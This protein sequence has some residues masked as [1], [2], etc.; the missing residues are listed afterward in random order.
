MLAGPAIRATV[1]DPAV[2]LLPDGGRVRVPSYTA[3]WLGRHG[4]VGGRRPSQ[5]RLPGA[6]S[7]LAALYDE[8]PAAADRALLLAIGVL[9]E[10]DDADPADVLDR[11]ADPDR[12]LTRDQLR[13]WD[14]W[15]AA[16][17]QGPAPARVRAVRDGQ[18]VVVEAADAVVVDAPDLLALLGKLAIVPVAMAAAADLA[19]RLDLLL[20]S[21]LADY[22]VVS[23]GVVE[24]DAVVHDGLRVRD[25]DG[26]VRDV[27]W[28]LV[29]DVLHVDRAAYAVGLGRG[30]AWRDGEWS[31]RHRRTEALGHL[32]GGSI[33][34]NEDDLDD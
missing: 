23:T 14:R 7:L 28:R 8:A 9:D 31:Q 3:W 26:E 12:T 16:S 10:L 2:V 30:R 4:V 25:A 20:A 11:L 32:V 13:A 1:V 19:D 33:M 22:A 27:A 24:G 29:D 5:W 18:V 34:E 21:E 17:D 6:D 15:I